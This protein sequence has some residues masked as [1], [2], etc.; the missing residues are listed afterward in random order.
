M[1]IRKTVKDKKLEESERQRGRERIERDKKQRPAR[2]KKKSCG[3][4]TVVLKIY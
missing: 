2:A 4:E 1:I 3:K